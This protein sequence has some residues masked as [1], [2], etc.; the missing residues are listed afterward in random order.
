MKKVRASLLS[1]VVVITVIVLGFLLP[2]LFLEHQKSKLLSKVD[3]IEI[4]TDQDDE[5]S[6]E[7][8]D[9]RDLLQV[10]QS[11]HEA[12]GWYDY[13][14]QD[15]QITMEEAWQSAEQTVQEFCEQG[16]LPQ[17]FISITDGERN[18]SNMTKFDHGSV[19]VESIPW[20][21]CIEL[22][23]MKE[24]KQLTMY[25]NPVNKK[26]LEISVTSLTKDNDTFSDPEHI[27]EQYISYLGLNNEKYSISGK[28]GAAE[29]KMESLDAVICVAEYDNDYGIRTL[30]IYVQ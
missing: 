20:K 10:A 26:V 30:E 8:M 18:G 28:S 6:Q 4:A 13:E 7:E 29:V 11:Y 9:I 24:N 5:Q 16:I 3:V 12:D 27:L 23:Y 15:N 25:M 1:G 17:S 14:L 19:V 22:R 2:S 21:G